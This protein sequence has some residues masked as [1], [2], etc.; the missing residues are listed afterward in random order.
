[1]RLVLLALLAFPLAGNAQMYKCVDARGVTSYSDVP[2]PGCKGKEVDIR[3]QPP[4]SGEVKESRSEPAK[5][6]AEFKRRQ[7]ERAAQQI[8]E[9]AALA[10]RQKECEHLKNEYAR[11]DSG[12]RIVTEVSGQG[13]R[14]FLDDPSRTRRMQEI[15]EKLATCP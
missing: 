5:D 2:R 3:G 11:L 15:R 6:E 1:M 4:I 9:Q 10:N 8:Q 13:E 12:R 14:S 7:I